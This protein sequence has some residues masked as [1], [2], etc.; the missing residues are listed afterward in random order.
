MERRIER[1]LDE[2]TKLLEAAV[3]MAGACPP[4]TAAAKAR[5][6]ARLP[7]PT[8]P[9]PAA[10]DLRRARL[11]SGKIGFLVDG[12]S[13]LYLP[14]TLS[15]LMKILATSDKESGDG[16]VGWQSLDIICKRL[17]CSLERSV[18]RHNL[19]QL[20]W[21]LR[22]ELK[23]AALDPRLVEAGQLG[24]RLRL[25]RGARQAAGNQAD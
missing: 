12:S 22:N 13:E 23:R 9:A 16:L 17:E 10:H 11:K 2:V 15:N 25:K 3:H 21:R 20:M 8:G 18:S 4:A 19:H 7:A 5:R 14:P 24:A 6:Q 1:M